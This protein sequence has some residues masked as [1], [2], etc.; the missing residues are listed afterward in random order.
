LEFWPAG[1]RAN[2]SRKLRRDKNRKA[3]HERSENEITAAFMSLAEALL[4][5]VILIENVPG[6]VQGP[7]S[8]VAW[9]K[10][11]LAKINRTHK[12]KYTLQHRQLDAVEYGVP[13]R[14]ERAILIACRDGRKFSWPEPTHTDHPI[15]A[16]DALRGLRGKN[17]RDASGK[18]AALLPS[19]PEGQNY[20]W[21]TAK[22]GGRQLFGYRTRYWSFL[23]KLSKREPSWT[24]SAFPG[25]ATG[26]FHWKIAR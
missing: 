15:R 5:R 23:L 18:W 21:H 13:Q 14:R 9:L 7:T 2:P 25:P 10:H 11:R 12:T 20:L 16:Y 8:T 3:R 17:Q 26:P 19:V 24:L 22:G 1:R 4:P 6:F